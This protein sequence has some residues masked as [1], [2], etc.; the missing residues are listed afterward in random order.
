MQTAAFPADAKRVLVIKHG[1]FGDVIQAEGALRDIRA[2]HPHAH[3]AVLTTPA[4]RG[5]IARAPF[6]DEVVV[7]ARTPRWRL[8]AMWALRKTLRAGHFDMIYDLQNSSRTAFYF[9]W[10]LKDCRWSGTAKGC[11]HPHRAAEP[12]KIRTLD[13]LA[14]QLADAGLRIERTLT[15]D[16]SWLADDVSELLDKAGARKPY[17]VLVPGCS[18][19]H[20]QKRW[21]YYDKLAAALI[22]D[23][24]E[25][26]L[27][28]GPDEVE[29]AR[30]I[31]GIK[32]TDTHGLL[33]WYELAGVFK[34]ADFVVGNDTGPSHLASHIGTPG[35]ALFGSYSPAERTGIAREN[36]GVIEVEDLSA[37]A[38]ERVLAEVK[39]RLEAV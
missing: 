6:I 28:P 20:P 12:K 33:S 4:Y 18:A 29:L 38:V 3:I 10:M 26:V 2:N 25:V 13:R 21:P 23:G 17:I 19:R 11:S 35:L 8:D 14:G 34:N 15:P 27:A 16:V 24:H 32:L 22:A 7:D 37:L 9:R 30:T 5:L 39:R 36:F 1:A 31:P